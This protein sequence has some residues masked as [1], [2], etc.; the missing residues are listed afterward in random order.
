MS[1]NTPIKVAAGQVVMFGGE[2]HRGWLAQGTADPQP[3]QRS[4]VVLNFR[5]LR[6]DEGYYLEWEPQEPPPRTEANHHLW[7]D[8]WLETLD[9]AIRQAQLTFGLEPTVWRDP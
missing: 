4:E 3:E 7:G 1:G 9:D 5:I 6:L 2:R 8:F